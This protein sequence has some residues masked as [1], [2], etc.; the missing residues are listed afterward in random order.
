MEDIIQLLNKRAYNELIEVAKLK[1]SLKYN[2]DIAVYLVCGYIEIGDLNNAEKEVNILL[3]KE[4]KDVW[5]KFLKARISY[6]KKEFQET[7][8][9]LLKCLSMFKNKIPIKIKVSI[10]NLLAATYKVL[11]DSNTSSKYYLMAYK[12]A[13]NDKE[14]AIE[15]SNYLFCINYLD[16]MKDKEVFEA[17]Y[18]YDSIYKNLNILNN[19]GRKKN[20]KIKI[21]Y[22][23][24]DF[25]K[26]VVVFFSFKFLADYDKDKF[27]VI[28]Y[29]RGN[30]DDISIQ[31]KN[32]VNGWK[33]ISCCS[34]DEAALIIKED[35]IDILFDLSGHTANSCLPILAR[36][37]API[38][39]SGIGYF[40]TTGLK[41]VD[42][43]L[44]DINCDPIGEND[45]LFTE[46]LLRL[47]HS[48]FCYTASDKMPDVCE[49]VPSYRNGY[50]TFGSFNN[51]TKVNDEMLKI[52]REILQKVDNS[53]LILKSNVFDSSYGREII[54]TR[55]KKLGFNLSQIELRGFTSDYLGEYNEIDVALDTYPYPGGGTTCDALYMGVPVVSL[56][57]QRHGSRFGYSILKNLGMEECIAN[58]S[59]EYI[60]K[61][62]MLASDKKKLLNLRK[63]LRKNMEE[64]P[65]MNGKLYM[66]CVEKEYLKIYQEYINKENRKNIISELAPLVETFHQGNEYILNSLEKGDFSKG[67]EQVINDTIVGL[68]Y[69]LDI[70][71]NESHDII[72][73]II[74]IRKNYLKFKECI[75]NSSNNC[76][77]NHGDFLNLLK[78]L[79]NE[80]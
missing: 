51:F 15:Y 21:G 33:N 42:Y 72:D 44:T 43:F 53:K 60:E 56:I 70:L 58:S 52:W 74:Y 61:T 32:M 16:N 48:H 47:P 59:E 28:C 12:S 77:F 63:N 76:E 8:N 17:H 69:I 3:K 66:E 34:D 68:D 50:I 13:D 10:Y 46:K 22:I 18:R 80:G 6:M 67:V 14:R 27:E 29:A 23:S 40:N 41:A 1:L 35:N 55:L 54:N 79:K 39:I 71:A 19:T 36:K 24:P 37:P 62:I 7:I 75:E 78:I 11:G 73:F 49:I 9:I 4:P 38:Q 26:H 25:R 57:G 65:L 64:S 5:I 30:E 2:K 31:L 20:S 45:N